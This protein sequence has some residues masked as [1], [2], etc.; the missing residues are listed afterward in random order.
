MAHI[1][2]I[3]ARKF[4]DRHA[5]DDLVEQLA[6]DTIIVTSGCKGVCTWASEKAKERG[7]EVIVYSPDLTDIRAWFEA[8]RRYYERNRELI[9]HCDLVHTFFSHEHGYTGGTRF[10]AH[11]AL[12]R[13]KP[14]VVHR[15]HETTELIVQCPVP[16]R[17]PSRTKRDWL[18]FFK[19]AL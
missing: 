12:K 18:E 17:E 6:T 16:L 14:V 1:G 2:I 4:T 8:A 5:V 3:G 15:E 11:Y 9:E 19:Q 13:G 10:E 7:L